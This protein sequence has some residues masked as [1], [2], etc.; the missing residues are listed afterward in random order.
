M[1][2]CSELCVCQREDTT[3][4]DLGLCIQSLV[5]QIV[6]IIGLPTTHPPDTLTRYARHSPKQPAPPSPPG[7]SRKREGGCDRECVCVCVCVFA[8]VAF[9]IPRTSQ[10]LRLACVQHRRSRNFGIPAFRKL[11][12]WYWNQIQHN[13][14]AVNTMPRSGIELCSRNDR[15]GLLWIHVSAAVDLRHV[16]RRGKYVFNCFSTYSQRDCLVNWFCGGS[17]LRFRQMLVNTL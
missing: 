17:V 10:I 9:S 14:S 8:V 12:A 15:Q 11:L 1:C 16:S 4:P 13:L 2:I 6:T 3:R 5:Q 7:T